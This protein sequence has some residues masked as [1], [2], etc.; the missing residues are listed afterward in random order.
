MSINVDKLQHERKF[1]E[2][3]IVKKKLNIHSV[4]IDNQTTISMF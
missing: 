1:Q 3:L 2:P 4:R